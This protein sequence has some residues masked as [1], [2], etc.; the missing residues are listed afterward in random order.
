MVAKHKALPAIVAADPAVQT[1]SHAV[2]VPGSN[3]TIANGRFCIALKPRD[4]RDAS[5]RGFIDR[6]RPKLLGIRSDEHTSGL[7]SLTRLPYAVFCLQATNPEE[8]TQ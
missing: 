2:G 8:R 1:F 5:A 3:Q 7:T 4:Q 6:I